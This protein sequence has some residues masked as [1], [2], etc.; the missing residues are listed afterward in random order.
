LLQRGTSVAPVVELTPKRAAQEGARSRGVGRADGLLVL[1]AL[2]GVLAID[3]SGIGS[4]AWS[5]APGTVRTDGALGSLVRLSHGHWD[6]ASLRACAVAAM[7]FVAL[8]AFVRA[9]SDGRWRRSTLV[10]IALIA[11]SGALVPAVLLQVALREG[12]APWFY[13]NDSTYQIELAG[14]LARNGQNPYGHEY[15]GSGMERFYTMDGSPVRWHMPALSHF[16]YFPGSVELSAAWRS[17]PAPL[18]DFRLAVALATLL[19]VPAALLF[20]G[21]FGARLAVGSVLACN[22][23]SIRLA[24]FGNADA[25]CLL[26]LVVAFGLAGRGR[27]RSAAAALAVAVLMKQFAIAAAPFLVLMLALRGSRRDLWQSL[28]IGSAVLAAGFLPFVLASPSALWR[29]TVTYGTGTFHVVSYGLAGG[30]VRLGLVDRDAAD[31]PVIPLML[32]V[33]LPVTAYAVRVGRRSREP[34]MAGAGFTL[35]IFTMIVIS[36]VFQSSYIVY[37]LSGAL[38]TLLLALEPLQVAQAARTGAAVRLPGGAGEP[39]SAAF[40]QPAET[41]AAG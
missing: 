36:R 29:D 11:V 23:V 20:P 16:A 7:A 37:P 27:W 41:R 34:W 32:L 40:P 3:F 14:D 13:T 30:L 8:C 33:W 2:F 10:A 4:D 5:F 17:L 1:A 12:T 28:G 38:I 25:I 18:N 31:Y 26:P 19:L 39:A 24:W 35:S 6:V 15:R 9:A 21:P 22:P